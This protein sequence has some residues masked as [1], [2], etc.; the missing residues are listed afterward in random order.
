[1]TTRHE[2]GV[3]HHALLIRIAHWM[4]ALATLIMI[5]SGWRIYDNSP[6]FNFEFPLWITLGGDP[7]LSYDQHGESGTGTAIAWHFAGMWLLLVAFLLMVLYGTLSGHFRRDFLPVTPKSFLRDLA[8]AARFRLEHELGEYNAVQKALY[9][10]VLLAVLM[11]LLS[12]LAIWKPVQLYW[13]T[14]LFGGYEAARVVHFLVMSAIVA[15]L[16]VHV[17][18]VVLVPKTLVS[19]VIG[20]AAAADR[21]GK[22]RAP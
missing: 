5:G 7:D 4:L 2:P 6:L 16:V 14:A 22:L 18:L 13:L 15:F 12:G 19:M 17:S 8:A 9:S 10:G 21:T 3:Q 20:R 11:M 1:M